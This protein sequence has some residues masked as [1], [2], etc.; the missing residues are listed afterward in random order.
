ME[1]GALQHAITA[2][3]SRRTTEPSFESRAA[4]TI[5]LSCVSRRALSSSPRESEV[6]PVGADPSLGPVV[7]ASG[8]YR[9]SSG[10]PDNIFDTHR[11]YLVGLGVDA[12]SMAANSSWLSSNESAPAFSR[13]CSGLVAPGIKI[14]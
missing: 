10:H 14:T 3:E 12:R 4:T 7:K 11:S 8:T 5:M 6:A 2:L 13:T 1:L 9:P